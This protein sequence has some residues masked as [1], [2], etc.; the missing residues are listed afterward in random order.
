MTESS[1]WIIALAYSTLSRPRVL[2]ICPGSWM[3][4]HLTA[5]CI[6]MPFCATTPSLNRMRLE[7]CTKTEAIQVTLQNIVSGFYIGIGMPFIGLYFCVGDRD[8]GL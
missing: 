5:P 1:G 3:T 2:L 6:L 8:N 4:L 7:F